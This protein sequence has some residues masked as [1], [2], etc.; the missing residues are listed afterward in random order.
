MSLQ[1]RRDRYFRLGGSYIDRVIG[2]GPIA[3]WPLD[4]GSG[5]VARCL[6]NPAQNGAYTGVTLANDATGPFG[7]PA[8]YFD[9]ANDYVNVFTAALDAAFN[10]ATGTVMTWGRVFNAGVWTDAAFR[11]TVR[12][13]D[14][15][16]NYYILRKTNVANQ[17]QGRGNAGGGLA[18]INAAYSSTGWFFLTSTWSDGN[19]ADEF[20]LFLNGAQAGAPSAVLNAWSGGGLFANSTV[21]GAGSTIPDEL[22][23]GWLAHCAVWDRVLSAGEIATLANP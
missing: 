8:P 5:A 10:G 1:K 23:H 20:K 16:N 15:G 21:I 11:Q 12:L 22:W 6:V 17:L 14:D 18:T 2:T 3:Y 4:E 7:T 9:G 13:L 19:N